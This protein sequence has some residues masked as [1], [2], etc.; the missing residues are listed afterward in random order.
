MNSERRIDAVVIV[1]TKRLLIL[2][3]LC[4][5]TVFL[6][7]GIQSAGIA[8]SIQESPV[9]DR[10]IVKKSDF[11]P[12]ANITVIKTKKRGT[13]ETNTRFLDDDDWIRGLEI[14]VVNDSNKT[15]TYLGMELKF[16]PTKDQ[17]NGL[18]AVWPFDYGLDPFWFENED[19]MP[20]RQVKPV[21][22]GS[23][24][25]VAL[26]D[27]EYDEIKGFLL[28]A[29]FPSNLRRLEVRVI[30]I[31]FSDGS[32]WNAGRIY[33]RLPQRFKWR[34]PTDNME[35]DNT[36]DKK[37]IGSALSR[38]AL[39][40][41]VGVDVHDGIGSVQLRPAVWA[42]FSPLPTSECGNAYMASASCN[43]QGFDCRYDLAE[44]NPYPAGTQAIDAAIKPCRGACVWNNR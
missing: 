24:V 44:L 12:P 30:K 29:G 15:V 25:M 13:V 34:S 18:P 38:T 2:F 3:L 36:P 40:L 16:R 21:L 9:Q 39:F 26:S 5:G 28:H 35:L 11:D 6:M 8:Q 19:S 32:A 33:R 1:I 14:H 17:A 10:I 37:P 42:G 31:G 22:P 4:L 7:R 43:M 27:R 41:K 20:P 23:T